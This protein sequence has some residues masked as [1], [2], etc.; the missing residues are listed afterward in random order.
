MPGAL[1]L[2]PTSNTL[3][4]G[5]QSAAEMLD[6]LTSDVKDTIQELRELAH[7]IYPPL[8]ADRGLGEAL[9][10]AGNRNPLPVTVSAGELGRYG[11]EIEA[12]IYFCCLE[13]LQ[14]AAKHADGA[15]V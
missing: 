7:G 5:P 1:G 12:A 2:R 10:A 11:P 8:L 14:N 9:R 4:D 6:Q 15:H 3:A 13:A